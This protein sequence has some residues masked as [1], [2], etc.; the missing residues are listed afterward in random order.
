M[1]LL[2]GVGWRERLVG[3]LRCGFVV[4][5]FWLSSRFLL[6]FGVLWCYFV[7]LLVSLLCAVCEFCNGGVSR[8]CV[9]FGWVLV[10]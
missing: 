1:V 3:L 4:Y 8:F 9:V 7:I 10:L 2:V 5:G 6:S